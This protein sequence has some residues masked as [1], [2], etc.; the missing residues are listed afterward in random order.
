MVVPSYVGWERVVAGKYAARY[1][2]QETIVLAG[3]EYRK[4]WRKPPEQEMADLRQDSAASANA[5][6]QKYRQPANWWPMAAQHTWAQLLL[7]L[8]AGEFAELRFRQLIVERADFIFDCYACKQCRFADT[9]SFFCLELVILDRPPR[10]AEDSRDFMAG[11]AETCQ[12]NDLPL[13]RTE[14][15]DASFHEVRHAACLSK[16]GVKSKRAAD[17]V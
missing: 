14:G 16:G 17:Q 15:R 9:Q 10:H 13:S 1:R 2:D 7:R 4:R 3:A 11:A 6:L 8:L 5:A 12:S